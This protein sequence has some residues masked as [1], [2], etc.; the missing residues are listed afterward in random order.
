M[1]DFKF[2]KEC[3]FV[4]LFSFFTFKTVRRMKFLQLHEE[5]KTGY[6]VGVCVCGM[7]VIKYKK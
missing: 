1:I 4:A 6:S 7:V 5:L 3:L 2:K